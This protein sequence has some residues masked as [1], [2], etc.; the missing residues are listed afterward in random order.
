M[1]LFVLGLLNHTNFLG[2]INHTYITL[3]PKIKHPKEPSDLRSISLCNVIMKLIIKC[4]ASQ[5]KLFLNDIIHPSKFAL[6]PGPI[7]YRKYP[8]CLGIIS[9]YES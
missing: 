1:I 9:F 6:I 2:N 7:H 3:I 8:Y 5:L 4:I